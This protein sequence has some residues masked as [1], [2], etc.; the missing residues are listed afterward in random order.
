MLLMNDQQMQ[1]L[2][3]AFDQAVQWRD[4]AVYTLDDR[5]RYIG[6]MKIPNQ[7]AG[8][9]FLD[10]L[11]SRFRGAVPAKKIVHSEHQERAIAMFSDNPE[12]LR[13][14]LQDAATAL[15]Y[16]GYRHPDSLAGFPDNEITR[17]FEAGI[18]KFIHASK[19]QST[20][21]TYIGIANNAWMNEATRLMAMGKIMGMPTF[22]GLNIE[23]SHCEQRN[24]K[25]FRPLLKDISA[26]KDTALI[27][28]RTLMEKI[29]ADAP[30][31]HAESKNTWRYC[32]DQIQE[33]LNHP[34]RIDKQSG[35]DLFSACSTISMIAD[36]HPPIGPQAH[37][38]FL[39]S[40]YI[41]RYQE[42]L[43]EYGDYLNQ[44]ADQVTQL[45]KKQ[46]RNKITLVQTPKGPDQ[47]PRSPTP[48][49]RP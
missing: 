6:M 49:R 11:I 22:Y 43:S 14:E 19:S 24:D 8:T 27:Y 23:L 29:P 10:H 44:P 32:T 12:K 5:D 30:R 25:L 15:Q 21:S 9:G 41:A 40:V 1:E 18:D 34:E 39:V 2:F 13:G 42:I 3:E 37:M 38:A 4:L 36:G 31:Q 35:D 7:G 48:R 47:L 26:A 28:L 16:L 17:T 33:C 20:S 45:R 46:G